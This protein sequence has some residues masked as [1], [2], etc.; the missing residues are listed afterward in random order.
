MEQPKQPIDAYTSACSEQAPTVSLALSPACEAELERWDMY[1]EADE[2]TA[3]VRDTDDG[4][5][6]FRVPRDIPAGLLSVIL[7]Y[8]QAQHSAG[9]RAG[10][11]EM[12]HRLRA[13]IGAAPL[14]PLA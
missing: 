12:Q 13:L 1:A 11:V 4:A 10:T 8:G 3:C 2:S 5:Y 6:R 14:E 9:V 7:R